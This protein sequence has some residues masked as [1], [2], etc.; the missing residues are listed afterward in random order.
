MH[1]GK[2][3]IQTVIAL[4]ISGLVFSG[5]GIKKGAP[6][7]FRNQKKSVKTLSRKPLKRMGYTIQ[8]GAFSNVKNAARLTKQL[9]D[10]GL[11]ATYFA[12]RT[13]LYKVRF[14]DFTTKDAALQ[15][16]LLLKKTGTIG[17]FYIVAP[18]E[19]SVAR[20]KKYGSGQD[21]YLRDEIV[22]A[23]ESFIDVPYLWGGTSAD[24]GFD[25]SGL[26][27]TVY[28]LNG[29]DLPRTSADQ[30]DAGYPIDKK[31]LRKGDLVF[32]ATTSSRRISHVGIYVGEGIFIHSPKE[33]K[34]IC[35]TSLSDD[36]F[37]RTY[38]GSCTYFEKQ[39]SV[40]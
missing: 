13:G 9:C 7:P 8:A 38:V 2:T 20:S 19:Y 31:D 16:A 25:C 32:F 39:P 5:C 3:I 14:G 12:A 29:L 34:K 40:Q 36:Y 24:T 35:R 22:K 10:S 15:K 37:V 17:E 21:D 1:P 26:A 18:E 33:G 6:S 28:E 27:M 4:L 23:A 30:Y 11:N